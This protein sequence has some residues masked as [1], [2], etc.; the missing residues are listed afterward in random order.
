[1]SKKQLL[2]DSWHRYR[3]SWGNYKSDKY[4]SKRIVRGEITDLLHLG[5]FSKAQLVEIKDLIYNM[6]KK[7]AGFE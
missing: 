3:L 5:S 4:K 6:A 7:N 2:Q 1:M